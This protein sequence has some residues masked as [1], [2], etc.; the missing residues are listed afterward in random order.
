MTAERNRD[1]VQSFERGLA[2]I[3]AFGPDHRQLTLSRGGRPG[4]G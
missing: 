1:F 2:V 3:R 4:P